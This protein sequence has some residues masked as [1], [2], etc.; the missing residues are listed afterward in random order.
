MRV[1]KLIEEYL[2]WNFGDRFRNGEVVVNPTEEKAIDKYI[3]L[4]RDYL[5]SRGKKRL[6]L[7][8]KLDGCLQ[9]LPLTSNQRKAIIAGKDTFELFTECGHS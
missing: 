1:K 4:H 7:V 5:R 8:E 2:D 9:E 3:E 6:E